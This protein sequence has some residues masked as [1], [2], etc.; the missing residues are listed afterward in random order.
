[1]YASLLFH[2]RF[3]FF[4]L[5]FLFLF[6]LLLWVDSV[7]VFLVLPP[8]Q[9]EVEIFQCI[10][11]WFSETYNALQRFGFTLIFLLF[12]KLIFPL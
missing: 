9:P 11:Y 10:I 5:F 8:K 3:M 12:A 1:M 2:L 4:F 6:F 7:A